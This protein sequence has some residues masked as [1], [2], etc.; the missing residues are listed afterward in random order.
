MNVGSVRSRG[1]GSAVESKR[2]AGQKR[3][4]SDR[5]MPWTSKWSVLC[6][7]GI[8]VS[9]M[10]LLSAAVTQDEARHHIRPGTATLSLCHVSDTTK[11][12]I[13]VFCSSEY[14]FAKACS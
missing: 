13:Y 7:V 3:M 2:E 9:T 1:A 4:P 12:H 10:L 8:L 6:F 5:N 14:E 11:V